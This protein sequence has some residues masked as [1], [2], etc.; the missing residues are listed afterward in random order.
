MVKE[1][2]R[3]LDE[4]VGLRT[5]KEAI[6]DIIYQQRLN[7]ETKRRGMGEI[8]KFQMHA[9]AAGP[10]GSGKTTVMRRLAGWLKRL[11]ALRTGVFVEANR[12][13]LVGDVQGETTKMTNNVLKSALGGVLFIDEAHQLVIDKQDSYGK[14]A[15]SAIIPF[16]ENHRFDICIVM[17]GYPDEMDALI[18][19]DPGIPS[20]F[21]MRFDFDAYTADELMKIAPQIAERELEGHKLDE[22]ALESLRPTCEIIASDPKYG[23]N[24]RALRNAIAKAIV[25]KNRRL[26]RSESKEI[27]ER[28]VEDFSV[29]RLTDMHSESERM[30]REAIDAI[31]LQPTNPAPGVLEA[32]RQRINGDDIG[33]YIL[34]KGGALEAIGRNPVVF[35]FMS[36]A[37]RD[38]IDVA[39][40][41][42]ERFANTLEFVGASAADPLACPRPVAPPPTRACTWRAPTGRWLAQPPPVS[43]R[44]CSRP[45]RLGSRVH[46]TR[47]QT[48]A[49]GRRPF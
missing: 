10:P 31:E 14:E 45:W 29:L 28:P 5:V 12:G 24:A 8:A 32:S 38:D 47:T 40:K 23:G 34:T 26:M 9:I 6:V 19:N 20:R 48:R 4:L 30:Q 44:R 27:G 13:K 15:L 2:T 7:A 37:L 49:G 33:A 42:V 17:A 3:E 22:E 25:R 16:A 36:A 43:R 18:K 46:P 21:T 11:G 39:T 35:E 1:V 41:A